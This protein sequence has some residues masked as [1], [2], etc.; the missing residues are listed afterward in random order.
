MLIRNVFHSE[1]RP[2]AEETPGPFPLNGDSRRPI[3]QKPSPA[4]RI[5]LSLF[6]F[7][8]KV[9]R[10]PRYRSSSPSAIIAFRCPAP[11]NESTPKCRLPSAAM[12]CLD[13]RRY[14]QLPIPQVHLVL[15]QHI[16]RSFQQCH[17]RRPQ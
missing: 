12:R 11:V 2:P 5:R 3:A 10:C 17:H 16:L 8:K 14:S 1:S 15:S 6:G 13:T 4:S 9:T 7:S